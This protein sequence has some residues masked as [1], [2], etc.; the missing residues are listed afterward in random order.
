[1][2]EIGY[3][4]HRVYIYLRNHGFYGFLKN[5]FHDMEQKGV[6]EF[7]M[8]RSRARKEIGYLAHR[9]YIYL[10]NPGF[11]GILRREVPNIQIKTHCQT[12]ITSAE[13]LLSEREDMGNRSSG[14][15][16]RAHP[17]HQPSKPTWWLMRCVIVPS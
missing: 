8:A 12:V 3:L 2:K 17:F 6:Y 15:W 9:V 16:F 14:R 13:Q 1:M 11:Q 10:R 5:A 7:L 4:A